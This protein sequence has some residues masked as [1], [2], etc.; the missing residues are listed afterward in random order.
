MKHISL[1]IALVF[2]LL[3]FGG[4][5]QGGAFAPN[6]TTP[7]QTTPAQTMPQETT[8]DVIVPEITTPVVTT[9]SLTPTET[10][11]QS[12]TTPEES[13]PEMTTPEETTPEETTLEPQP[14]EH[15]FGEATVTKE[16]TCV[17]NGI[18][19]AYCSCGFSQE[20]DIPATGVHKYVGTC[21]VLCREVDPSLALTP[22]VSAYDAN[23]DGEN[24]V[25]YFSTKLFDVFQNGTH[26]WAGDYDK[27]LSSSSIGNATFVNIKHWYVAEESGQYIVYRVTVP[28]AGI[29]EMAIH[30]RMKDSNERGTKYT[31]NEGTEYEQIFE[32]SHSFAEKDGYLT[33][34]DENTLGTYMYGIRLNLVEGENFI[35]IEQSSASPKN[36]HYRDFYFVKVDAFHSHRY[37]EGDVIK[38]PTCGEVGY[39][40]ISCAC[41]KEKTSVIPATREH[42]YAGGICTTCGQKELQMTAVPSTYDNDGDGKADV[43]AFSPELLDIFKTENAVHVWAGK[44]DE[45]LSTTVNSTTTAGIQHWYVATNGSQHLVYVINVPETGIYEMVLHL[46]M[47]DGDDRGAKYIINAGTP[48]EQ[49][50]E[51]S[52]AFEGT[53]YKLVRNDT[54]GTYMYGIRVKLLEGENIIDVTAASAS[55]KCQ[56]YRDFYFVKVGEFHLHTLRFES[57]MQAENCITDGKISYVCDCGERYIETVPAT[58]VHTYKDDVCIYC[59]QDNPGVGI[60]DYVFTYDKAGFAGGK[61]SLI[62]ESS[63]TYYLYW[64]NADGI[65]PNYSYLYSV[66]L[67]AGVFAEV[68][69]HDYTAIPQGATTLVAVSSGGSNTY[70]F[71]LPAER[72]F[73]QEELYL[74]GAIADTHQGTRYGPE[75]KSFD[76]LI[77]AGEILSQKGAILIGINGDIATNNTEREYYLHGEAIKE[78]YAMNPNMPIYTVSGNHEA[79]Y[80]GFSR[81]WYDTYARN[82]V[83]YQTDFQ[84]IY[85]EDNDLDYVVELPDGSVIIFLHQVYYDYA[86]TTSRLLD[87]YQLDWLGDRLEQYKDRTV[88]LF[89]HTEMEG[90]VG[91]FSDTNL[92]MMQRTEDYKRFDAYFKQYTNVIFFNGH[93][94][95]TFEKVFDETRSDRVIN[96][97]G[98]E[99][100]TL[101]HLPSLA[102]SDIGHIVHVYEDYIV[103]EGYDFGNNESVAYGNFIIER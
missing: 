70:T 37:E 74:F 48:Y 103:F 17:Q 29:Y 10:T 58:R 99:Y 52:H 87:D 2:I 39:K 59:G 67:T 98:G 93:S 65:L 79:K 24:D 63:E 64:G 102:Y 8:A 56:H 42:T 50:I 94:H 53:E 92:L 85:T 5:M 34:R 22:V 69:I 1:L 31:V 91:H 62:S 12:I 66:S 43:Y 89:F 15:A 46:R 4:C 25:Y 60:I 88:F 81:E 18:K 33:V 45:T 96:T 101:A 6:Q 49:V 20:T 57:I 54:E 55:E 27:T 19:T 28:E 82:I 100:A 71:E 41:G 3:S 73:E 90:K 40:S 95:A 23:S 7:A 35:K 97:Y 76:R 78:I 83:E 84:A 13:A 21:C 77:N 36:Q 26:V 38:A 68:S 51:T 44:Y 86:K 9:S 61:V 14:H 75:T 30:M 47:K 80:T 32:T 11:H 72:L 16:P